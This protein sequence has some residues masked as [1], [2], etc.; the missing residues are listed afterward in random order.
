MH[1][2]AEHRREN[3]SL[4]LTFAVAPM[5]PATEK[6]RGENDP[7]STSLLG[8]SLLELISNNLIIY[9]EVYRQTI[10]EY[11]LF[12]ELHVDHGCM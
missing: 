10:L 4:H 12:D 6:T 9:E 7:C 2:T 11:G 3:L 5:P 8:S 1:I